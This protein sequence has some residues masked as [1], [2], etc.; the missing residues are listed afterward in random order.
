MLLKQITM[1]CLLL[2][3]LVAF[4][5]PVLNGSRI[6]FYVPYCAK[7]SVITIPQVAKALINRGHDVT[8]ATIWNNIKFD[9]DVDRIIVK[10]RFKEVFNTLSS[11]FLVK[12]PSKIDMIKGFGKMLEAGVETNDEALHQ[13]KK[14]NRVLVFCGHFVTV[15]LVLGVRR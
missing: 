12:S 8:I 13:L 4:C 5:V 2:F 1:K 10:S 15:V 14:C 9:E 3:F 11:K 7:S 6:L